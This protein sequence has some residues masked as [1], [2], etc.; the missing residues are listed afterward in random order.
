MQNAL[1]PKKCIDAGDMSDGNRIMLWGCNGYNQ[2]VWG[3]DPAMGTIYLAKSAGSN[4]SNADMCLDFTE[5]PGDGSQLIVWHC[6][7]L[8]DQQFDISPAVAIA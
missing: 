2:Q 8:S 6:N 4:A 5:N 1:E 7:G 3:Y